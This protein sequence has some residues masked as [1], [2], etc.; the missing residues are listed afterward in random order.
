[1]NLQK[2]VLK[3]EGIFVDGEHHSVEFVG[4]ILYDVLEILCNWFFGMAF[5]KTK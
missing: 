2:K 3:Q 4:K 5:E 1:M